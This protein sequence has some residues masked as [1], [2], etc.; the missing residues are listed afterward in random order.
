MRT[1]TQPGKTFS[2]IGVAISDNWLD[3]NAD[4]TS[5]KIVWTVLL[6]DDESPTCRTKAE[7]ILIQNSVLFSGLKFQPITIIWYFDFGT[8]GYFEPFF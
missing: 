6:R 7:S 3:S 2:F 8:Y 1:G 4:F 5:W